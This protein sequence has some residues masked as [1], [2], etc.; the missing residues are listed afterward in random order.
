M[1]TKKMTPTEA[2]ARLQLWYTEKGELKEAKSHEHMERVALADFYFKDPVEGTNR[3]DLGGG[4]D[5]K[6]QY[7]MTY[8]VDEP[9]VSAVTA[10]QIK[11]LKLPWDDLFVYKPTL[12]KSTYNELTLEQK[13]FVDQLLD[14]KPGSPALDIVPAAD[15]A[16]QEA[17]IAAAKAGTVDTDGPHIEIALVAEQA[18]PGQMYTDGGGNW[19]VLTDDYEWA[20]AAITPWTPK[21]LEEAYVVATT[22]VK[23]KRAP[24]KTAAARKAAKA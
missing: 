20:D 16:G 22:P 4:F 2:Y 18:T 1:P 14:I 11:K 13:K 19:W 15:R 3:L 24:R 9:A 23:K 6:L 17:H 8:S 21:Q 10:A 7:G 5:L 12:S